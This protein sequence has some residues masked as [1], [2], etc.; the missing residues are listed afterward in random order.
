MAFEFLSPVQAWLA[1]AVFSVFGPSY[2]A[3]VWTSQLALVALMLAFLWILRDERPAILGCGI[4]LL[5]S[6]TAVMRMAYL[7][8]NEG[9]M[10][11]FSGV[12]I[13]LLAG[14]PPAA[15]RWA[16]AGASFALAFFTK[17]TCAV[18]V[19]AVLACLFLL[20]PRRERP[21]LAGAFAGGFSATAIPFVL[22][23][24]FHGEAFRTAMSFLMYQAGDHDRPLWQGAGAFLFHWEGLGW[25]NTL[26]PAL[27]LAVPAWAPAALSRLSDDPGE[28][29]LQ[30]FGWFAASAL[31]G[32]VLFPAAPS[33]YAMAAL[34]L[35]YLAARALFEPARWT[36]F[37]SLS[38]R[39]RA[40]LAAWGIL[41]AMPVLS[42]LKEAAV[43]RGWGAGAQG[44]L[45][46]VRWGF[47][48]L[49][50]APLAVLAGRGFARLA[51]GPAPPGTAWLL[52]GAG[53]L[54]GSLLVVNI[55]GMLGR[56][57]TLFDGLLPLARPATAVL[58]A[59]WGGTFAL[60]A[61]WR[62][63]GRPPAAGFRWVAA[64][65]AG[66][67]LLVNAKRFAVTEYDDKDLGA[68]ARE[69]G[70]H[71]P[72][73]SVV[74]GD[75][76]T[77]VLLLPVKCRVVSPWGW[78]PWQIGSY[79]RSSGIY[80]WNLPMERFRPT[81]LLLANEHEID[82]VLRIWGPRLAPYD[83]E[84]LTTVRLKRGAIEDVI[85]LYALKRKGP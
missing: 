9:T 49:G 15:R 40:L 76:W 30:A 13:V 80:Q 57:P 24:A 36:H 83:R 66:L 58:A 4:F 50:A 10:L 7:G 14:P 2:E 16:A 56:F 42:F 69:L 17:F 19:P 23:I 6:D 73:D 44:V 28:R 55:D 41:A 33:R 51:A 34:P 84:L 18:F 79:E 43:E 85:R 48:L 12:G 26:L 29:R 45:P 53:F 60:A 3:A 27:L 71:I 77:D 81:R 63:F 74:Y 46:E 22:F 52:S 59:S 20:P 62:S 35:C 70:R 25:R 68:I 8:T 54:L 5:W 47:L 21:K 38:A 78:L 1:A 61:A 64:G 75:I 37:A 31:A 82:Q 72:E 65:F 39:G 11:L 67:A 32:L